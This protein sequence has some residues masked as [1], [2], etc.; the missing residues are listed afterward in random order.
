MLMACHGT[1]TATFLPLA[2]THLKFA[3]QLPSYLA[4]TKHEKGWIK[5]IERM[6][7]ITSQ[8]GILK[9]WAC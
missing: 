7:T 3:I 9:A 2:I 1:G 8:P 6:S 5:E 4:H